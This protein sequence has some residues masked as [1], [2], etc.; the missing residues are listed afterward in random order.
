[1]VNLTEKEK[2]ALLILFKDFSSYYNANSLSKK[3]SISHVGAQKLLKRFKEA[4]LINH[5]L[6]GK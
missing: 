5:I 6:C 4:G 3:I 2:E 1:M